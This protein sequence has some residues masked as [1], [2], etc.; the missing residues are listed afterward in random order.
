MASRY[1][2][3]ASPA[4]DTNGDGHTLNGDFGTA[5]TS[6]TLRFF[7]WSLA[8]DPLAD[9][10]AI[11]AAVYNAP[12]FNPAPDAG[13]GFFDPP[14]VQQNTNPW[15]IIWNFYRQVIIWRHNRDWA[16]WMTT[17]TDPATGTTI[18]VNRFYSDQ[19]PADYLFGSSPTNPNFRLITSGSPHWTADVAPFGSF[20]ITS[21]NIIAGAT[22][23][24][25]LRNVAPQAAGFGRWGLFEYNVAVG[26]VPSAT[27]L[28]QE[29]A[30]LVATRPSLI[31]PVFWDTDVPPF[32]IKGTP[33]ETLLRDLVNALKDSPLPPPVVNHPATPPTPTPAAPPSAPGNLLVSAIN[34]NSATLKWNASALVPAPTD[35]A[36]ASSYLLEVSG[37]PGGAVFFNLNVGNTTCFQGS[38]P[39]GTYYAAMRG[40]ASDGVTLGP[41][42]NEVLVVLPGNAGVGGCP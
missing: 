42:S 22:E 4:V 17:S 41:R 10:N 29:L 16:Q 23:L 19:V 39:D 25:T 2:G 1:A 5:F 31:I 12:G 40:V 26:G 6:W 7:D 8:H 34:G 13:A 30:S 35:H 14:R 33:F 37:T 21:F 11:P 32:F 3:D 9:P 15:W 36:P 24:P 20:G 18:P 38:G 28:A 27:F